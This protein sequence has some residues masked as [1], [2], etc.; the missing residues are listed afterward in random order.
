MWPM[1]PK[2][3]LVHAWATYADVLY[4]EEVESTNDIALA[5]ATRASRKAL[6]VGCVQRSGRGRRGTRVVF[7]AGCRALLSVIL[8]PAGRR[9]SAARDACGRCCGRPR[10]G[11]RV[12]F[13]VELK[14][15][16]DMVIGRPWRKM[17]G[18]LAR[19]SGRGHRC[20]GGRDWRG[21]HARVI[22]GRGGWAESIEPNWVGRGSRAG[23]RGPARGGCGADLDPRGRG[24]Q[25]CE[26]WR[27]SG[28]GLGERR[29]L[30][31]QAGPSGFAR[32]I[33]AD[34]ALLVDADGTTER[35]I[36]GEVIWE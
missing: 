7:A 4:I 18:V 33:D 13:P 30:A 15:P 11:A 27:R 14:W 5:L 3:V 34:G 32:D 25:V 21:S 22:R 20:R 16:N 23:P 24:R 35:V 31:D 28:S 10:D 8:R 6:R 36:A 12:R 29:A 1:Q 2:V 9:G 17:G 26:A 19:R